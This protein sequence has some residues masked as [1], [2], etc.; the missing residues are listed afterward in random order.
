MREPM[1]STLRRLVRPLLA[2]AEAAVPESLMTQET[3]GQA[4]AV[5]NLTRTLAVKAQRAKGMTEGSQYAARE[6][7]GK[8]QRVM[9]AMV[10]MAVPGST[11]LR[12]SEPLLVIQVGSGEEEAAQK[13]LAICLRKIRPGQAVS[14]AVGKAVMAVQDL[15]GP[16]RPE[17]VVAARR[18]RA[19]QDTQ[20][21]TAAPAL[22]SSAISQ[23]PT[24]SRSTYT[25]S[26][27]E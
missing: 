6:A 10:V 17:G 16:P 2:E 19:V 8:T 12:T 13:R 1:E 23:S 24:P 27:G 15:M 26:K 3:E 21:A 18:H 4:E 25:V 22:S 5:G 11:F 14:E 7:V 9:M 20:V